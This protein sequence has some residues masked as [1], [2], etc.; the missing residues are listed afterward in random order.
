MINNFENFLGKR[1]RR[2]IWAVILVALF[3]LVRSLPRLD[4]LLNKEFFVFMVLVVFC[5]LV[6][7]DENI[8]FWGTVYFL[9]LVIFN[10]LSQRG[11]SAE[12]ISNLLFLAFGGLV[13][14]KVV[15]FIK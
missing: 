4:Y 12:L 8:T 14:K 2:F 3:F 9:I 15:D 5:L 11:A 10:L 7:F 6:G 13:F 1:L